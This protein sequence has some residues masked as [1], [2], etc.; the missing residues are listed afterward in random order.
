M[1]L[2]PSEPLHRT[3]LALIRTV[4][5]INDDFDKDVK[6]QLPVTFPIANNENG[7]GGEFDG[8]P[9]PVGSKIW[10]A[11]CIR[12]SN[13]ILKYEWERVKHAE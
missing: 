4:H 3:F 12:F 6:S 13:V 8:V 7:E 1:L 5:G 2:N 9:D 11:R 10:K